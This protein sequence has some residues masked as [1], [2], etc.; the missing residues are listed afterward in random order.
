MTKPIDPHARARHVYP[1]EQNLPAD[2]Q[3]GWFLRATTKRERAY[4]QDV[5]ATA[6]SVAADDT[7]GDLASRAAKIDIRT[8]TVR[9]SRV[10]FALAGVDNY[11][12]KYASVQNPLG[13][14]P[15]VASDEFLDTIPDD[16]FEWL[17]GVAEKSGRVTVEEGK[18]S[19]PES[20][21]SSTDPSSSVAG[22][23]S[24]EQEEPTEMRGDATPLRHV[25]HTGE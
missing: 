7:A 5:G 17:A 11:A 4:C 19:S 25:A 22:Y 9:Y 23:A 8:G 6:L 1:P 10:R 12:V 14:G 3:T 24:V 13:V 2:Q 15:D 16:V 20:T 21:D 18:K